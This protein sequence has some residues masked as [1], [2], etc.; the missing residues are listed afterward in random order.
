MRPTALL[1]FPDSQPALLHLDCSKHPAVQPFAML[2]LPRHASRFPSNLP[3]DEAFLASLTSYQLHLPPPHPP[4][5]A[6]VGA[7]LFPLPR[8]GIF[9]LA[10]LYQCPDV[11]VSVY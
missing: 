1:C 4:Q 11:P 9:L 10:S 3:M 5:P 2:F 7:E 6:S 8:Q